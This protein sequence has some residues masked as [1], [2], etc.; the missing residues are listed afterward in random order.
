MST[1]IRSWIDLRRFGITFLTGESCGLG[2]RVLC[3]L[4]P[5]GKDLVEAFLGSTV[6]VL[7]DSNWNSG[8][9]GS[10]LMPHSIL[11][12]L[13][14]FVLIHTGNCEI[15]VR[16]DDHGGALGFSREEWKDDSTYR[17]DTLKAAYGRLRTYCAAGTAGTRNVHVMSG[18]VA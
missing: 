14:C 17:L 3:D 2:M 1:M 13:A 16:L 5:Q 11:G 15:A 6:K 7:D 12:E 9:V 8:G 4:T 10:V 18:R